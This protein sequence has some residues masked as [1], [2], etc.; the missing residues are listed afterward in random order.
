MIKSDKSQARFFYIRRDLVMNMVQWMISC[1]LVIPDFGHD[2]M[3]FQREHR[4]SH[5]SHDRGPTISF[6]PSAAHFSLIRALAKVI[7]CPTILQ[8]NLY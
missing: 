6:V 1:T 8:Y 7:L 4:E 5:Y 2:R 3:H